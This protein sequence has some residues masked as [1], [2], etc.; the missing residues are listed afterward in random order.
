MSLNRYSHNRPTKGL[1]IAL[2]VFIGGWSISC[3]NMGRPGGGPK[4]ETPPVLK[5]AHRW[6]ELLITTKTKSF[7]NLMKSFKS[8]IRAKKSSSLPLKPR[9]HKCRHW[10]VP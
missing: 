6:P 10:D 9:C 5:K 8:K 3:A 4:D 1:A 2:I 7:S